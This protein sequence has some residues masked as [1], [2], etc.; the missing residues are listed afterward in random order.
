V[1]DLRS[2]VIGA[3]AGALAGIFQDWIRERRNCTACG[4][5]KHS[6]EGS[7]PGGCPVCPCGRIQRFRE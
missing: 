6:F 5:P 1:A 2:L 7:F 4:H 3:I